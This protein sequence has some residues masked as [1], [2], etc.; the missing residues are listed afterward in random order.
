MII[1]FRTKRDING[2]CKYLGRAH[3]QGIYYYEII[4]MEVYNGERYE[5]GNRTHRAQTIRTQ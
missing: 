2:H 3:Y 4:N 1:H 5:E